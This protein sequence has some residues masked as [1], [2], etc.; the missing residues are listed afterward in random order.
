MI[1]LSR[2]LAT[3]LAA[4]A[5][6]AVMAV[7]AS[8]APDAASASVSTGQIHPV[9]ITNRK[10]LADWCL[11][12]EGI[13]AGSKVG[14]FPCASGDGAQLW[15]SSAVSLAQ[16]GA[17]AVVHICSQVAPLMCIGPV[18]KLARNLYTAELYDNSRPDPKHAG[19][20][21]S[22]AAAP[23]AGGRSI[24]GH[25]ASGVAIFLAPKNSGGHG[26]LVFRVTLGN[27]QA[28]QY[29]NWKFPRFKPVR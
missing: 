5:V 2:A 10:V 25:S 21:L 22:L 7:P 6:A 23:R 29:S 13:R 28:A 11:T 17:A 26:D 20:G 9:D 15:I 14:I 27:S 16:N 4:G 24:R 18:S 3:T 19:Y 12:A 1:R 8:A